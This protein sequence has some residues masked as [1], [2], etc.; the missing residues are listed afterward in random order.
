MSLADAIATEGK[1]RHEGH[2]AT[3]AK[4]GDLDN[5]LQDVEDFQDVQ[6]V[7]DFSNNI[8]TPVRVKKKLR[9]DILPFVRK[10]RDPTEAETKKRKKRRDQERNFACKFCEK[11]WPSANALE[12]HEASHT[13]IKPYKCQDCSKSFSQ[14]GNLYTH[15]RAVH[16]GIKHTCFICM[17]ELS[18]GTNLNHHITKTH[19]EYLAVHCPKCDTWMR[20]DLK[21]HQGTSACRDTSYRSCVE[22]AK[23][24]NRAIQMDMVSLDTEMRG[25]LQRHQETS[26]SRDTSYRSCLEGAKTIDRAI[27]MDMV[28]LDTEQEDEIADILSRAMFPIC[29]EP[30]QVDAATCIEG[31]MSTCIAGNMFTDVPLEEFYSKY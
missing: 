30:P 15:V 3:A 21:R 14:K 5:G 20:G 23:T 12:R 18:S 24:M 13:G 28:S 25:D 19:A 16:T 27:Q 1:M 26:A 17:Q 4:F 10:Y 8:S 7:E 29:I 11:K 2:E 6:D 9:K 22:G 31:D